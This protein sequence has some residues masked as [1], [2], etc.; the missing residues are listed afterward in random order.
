L[1]SDQGTEYLNQCVAEFLIDK[2]IELNY[3]SGYSPKSN[4][5][6]ERF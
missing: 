3:T 4:G 2:G 6:P 1:F 5:V